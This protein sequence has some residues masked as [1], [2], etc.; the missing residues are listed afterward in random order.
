MEHD[1]RPE[2]NKYLESNSNCPET[3]CGCIYLCFESSSG[4]L[5][6][7]KDAASKRRKK[8]V[9]SVLMVKASRRNVAFKFI[10]FKAQQLNN[11]RA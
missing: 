11:N 10:P 4:A 7:I 1:D 2:I 9:Y 6:G 8:V 3:N 5:K